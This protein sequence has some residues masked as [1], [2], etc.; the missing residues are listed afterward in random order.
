MTDG[1]LRLSSVDVT[2]SLD[3]LYGSVDIAPAGD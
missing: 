2:V 3:A 1:E